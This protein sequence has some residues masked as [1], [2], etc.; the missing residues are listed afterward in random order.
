[1]AGSGFF[2]SD[3]CQAN[4]RC[5]R[6][7]AIGAR[8]GD[9]LDLPTADIHRGSEDR[10]GGWRADIPGFPV[11]NLFCTLAPR[12]QFRLPLWSRSGGLDS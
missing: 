5:R 8:V 12:V 10:P 4:D 7:L 2:P 11:I 3:R 1:M 9:R 6:N